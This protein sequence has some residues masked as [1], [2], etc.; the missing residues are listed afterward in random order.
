MLVTF[1]DIDIYSLKIWGGIWNKIRNVNVAPGVCVGTLLPR[2]PHHPGVQLRRGHEPVQD[3]VV[4]LADEVAEAEDGGLGPQPGHGLGEAVVVDA[5]HEVGDEATA[6]VDVDTGED[7]LLKVQDTRTEHL[8][9]M[10]LLSFMGQICRI[11]E[12]MVYYLPV[13]RPAEVLEHDIAWGQSALQVRLVFKHQAL[14]TKVAMT[15]HSKTF[16]V[17][18]PKFHF[19]FLVLSCLS[20]KEMRVF[21][22]LRIGFEKFANFHNCLL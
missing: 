15:Q 18:T 21:L 17:E 12:G 1:I 20:Q 5:A 16:Q 19:L 2:V 4:E 3:L 9:L 10:L 8:I 6:D 22:V 7:E 14:A 13:M 11:I